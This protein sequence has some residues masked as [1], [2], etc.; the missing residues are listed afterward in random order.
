[1]LG[2]NSPE[3]LELIAAMDE[4]LALVHERRGPS[5]YRVVVVERKK[6]LAVDKVATF[7]GR[8][9][10]G[11]GGLFLVDRADGTV[12]TIR[13]YGKRGHRVS[14]VVRLAA[15]YRAASLTYRENAGA[16]WE[17]GLTKVASWTKP[18]PPTFS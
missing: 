16:H 9:G 18:T 4:N 7:E 12:Y 10:P 8:D 1:M 5:S 11:Q 14:E 2:A 15:E 3:V 17:T 6:Y 13:G